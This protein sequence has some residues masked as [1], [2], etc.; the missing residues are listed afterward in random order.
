MNV[1]INSKIAEEV[2]CHEVSIFTSHFCDNL[3]QIVA[4]KLTPSIFVGG[5]FPGYVSDL[6]FLVML[7]WRG[8]YSCKHQNNERNQCTFCSKRFAR[9][10][11]VWIPRK[12]SIRYT[13]IRLDVP[14]ICRN[15]GTNSLN[16]T[17]REM[18]IYNKQV[19]ILVTGN[20]HDFHLLVTGNMGTFLLRGYNHF[21]SI[22]MHLNTPDRI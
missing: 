3:Q 22:N 11:D 18:V 8:I 21:K 4:D 19:L 16:N 10:H 14:L 15:D 17:W 5:M 13:D 20:R 9:S 12:D 1:A 2:K 7:D 6:H